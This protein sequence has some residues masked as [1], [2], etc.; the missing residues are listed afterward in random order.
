M[1]RSVSSFCAALA[2]LL[3]SLGSAPA[4]DLH[5]LA[6]IDEGYSSL[7]TTAEGVMLVLGL[8]QPVPYRIETRLNPMRVV[9]E[10]REVDFS[11]AAPES[12]LGTAGVER[13]SAS[14]AREGWS[15][16]E[17]FLSEP[18]ALAEAE[19][20]VDEGVGTALLEITLT[21]VDEVTFLADAARGDLGVTEDQ[22]TPVEQEALAV[23]RQRGDRPL[24]VML[25]PGHGGFDPGAERDGYTEADLMLQ[26]ARELQDHL[27]RNAGYTVLMTRTEDEFVPLPERVARARAAG[28]DVFLSLHADALIAGEASGA[29]VY[30]LSDVASDAASARLAEQLDRASLLA[31]MDLTAQDD[32]VATALMDLARTEVRPRSNRLA[33]ALV[34]GI[35]ETVGEMHQRP[36]L[37]ADF[38]VLR[39]PDIPSALIELGFLSSDSDLE[40]LLSEEWRMQLA[41]GIRTALERW[42]IGDAAEADLIRQ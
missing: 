15:R 38:S 2:V 35:T 17:L 27:V 8:S 20:L 3:A 14:M 32:T 28:A 26:F 22:P 24:I 33:D 7:S 9:I 31:G 41:E 10:F 5:A 36:R 4:Q 40:R 39:A 13:V 6:R 16:L 12:Y 34:E 21:A 29:R 25:D 37:S 23:T 30:T 18:M 1:S 19:M 42:A 11:G